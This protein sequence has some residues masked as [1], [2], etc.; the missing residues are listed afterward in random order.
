MPGPKFNDSSWDPSW[1]SLWGWLYR[2]AWM[3]SDNELR[4]AITTTY[5]E[6]LEVV[7]KLGQQTG[8]MKRLLQDWKEMLGDLDRA[9]T[10]RE[11]EFVLEDL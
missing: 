2:T 6:A 8:E 1:M 9:I 11:A 10:Y 4:N 3:K 5:V 7:N